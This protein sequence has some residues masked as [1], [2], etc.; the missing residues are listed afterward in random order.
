MIKFTTESGPKVRIDHDEIAAV[1]STNIP[2]QVEIMLVNG[3]KFR[4]FGTVAEVF[5]EIE[6]EDDD[7]S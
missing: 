2:G 3:M 7:E 1:S 6:R 5:A 4:V